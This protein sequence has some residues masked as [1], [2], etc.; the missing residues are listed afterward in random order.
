LKIAYQLKQLNLAPAKAALQQVLSQHLAA[1]PVVIFPPSLH[2]YQKLFQR[3]QQLALALARQGCLV[4]YVQWNAYDRDSPFVSL[5]ERC[6]LA[7]CAGKD[8]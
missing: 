2:W 7:P 6:Y 4:F 5:D 1:H 8:V 3:P